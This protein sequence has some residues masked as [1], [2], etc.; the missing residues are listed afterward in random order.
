MSLFE[1]CFIFSHVMDNEHKVL[2]TCI[3]YF[4]TYSLVLVLVKYTNE[5]SMA[6]T[7]AGC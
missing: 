5:S 3:E 4:L 2:K 6:T 1:R 7:N